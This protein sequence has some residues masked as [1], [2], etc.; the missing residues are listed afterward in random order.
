[1]PFPTVAKNAPQFKLDTWQGPAWLSTS[2]MVIRGLENCGRRD[3]AAEAAWRIVKRVFETWSKRGHFFEFYNPMTGDVKGVE[4]PKESM[5]KSMIVGERPIKDFVGSTGLV[6]NLLVED[7][8]GV[9]WKDSKPV[10]VPAMP[11]EWLGKT[12]RYK[13]PYLK[14]DCTLKL[15]EPEK[16]RVKVSLPTAYETVVTNVVPWKR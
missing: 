1:M 16:V 2:Y 4:G 7:I 10:F 14:F 13:S 15:E 3:M 5:M 6:N 11:P 9:R 8:I 12:I